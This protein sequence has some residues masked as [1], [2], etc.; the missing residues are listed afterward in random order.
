[1]SGP[2]TGEILVML[3][4]RV[5]RLEAVADLAA[6]LAASVTFDNSGTNGQGGHGGLVS[7]ETIRGADDLRRALGAL[8]R[9][10]AS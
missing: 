8:G 10:V 3:A 4:H 5:D 9:E 6:A 7:R 1:M 2:S